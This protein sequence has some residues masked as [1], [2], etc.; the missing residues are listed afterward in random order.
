MIA[1]AQKIFLKNTK[2][3]QIKHFLINV[4]PD[5]EDAELLK[6][7]TQV[8]SQHLCYQ[9]TLNVESPYKSE[10]QATAAAFWEKTAPFAFW[11]LEFKMSVMYVNSADVAHFS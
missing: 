4:C 6:S 5:I 11:Y 3:C 9:W 8:A 7:Q 1:D 10:S 2:K